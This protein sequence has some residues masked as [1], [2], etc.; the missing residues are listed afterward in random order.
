MPDAP[1]LSNMKDQLVTAV[2]LALIAGMV[3]LAGT[4]TVAA[5][6]TC[7]EDFEI[8]DSEAA[9]SNRPLDP[10]EVEIGLEDVV[11]GTDETLHVGLRSVLDELHVKVFVKDGNDCDDKTNQMCGVST[12]ILDEFDEEATCTL[13]ASNSQDYFVAFTNAQSSDGLL[14][15]TWSTTP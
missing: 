11:S 4:P 9:A 2:A 13:D 7:V 1:E 15:E 8:A 14:Y 5:Q 10:S 6:G 3:G 12:V